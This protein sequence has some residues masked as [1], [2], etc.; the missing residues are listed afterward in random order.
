MTEIAQ[1]LKQQGG[2]ALIIDYGSFELRAGSTLQALKDHQKVDVLTHPGEADLTAHVDFELLKDVAEKNGADV[3]GL[4]M[5]GEWLRQMGI[6]VRHEALARKN[7]AE[8]DKLKRQYDRLVLDS[9][10]GML[11]KVLGVC[12]PRWPIG[13]GF[14]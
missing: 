12:G 10:M 13:V 14:D 7:P 5:Q 3:M 2:A 4:Q 9:Q 8:T 1:R 11:F 6:D